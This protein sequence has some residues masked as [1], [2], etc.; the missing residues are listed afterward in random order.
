MS[1]TF[2]HRLETFDENYVKSELSKHKP[3]EDNK[4]YVSYTADFHEISNDNQ[5]DVKIEQDQN[6]PNLSIFAQL[7]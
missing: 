5:N 4:D 3:I 6:D 2:F 1:A 7:F